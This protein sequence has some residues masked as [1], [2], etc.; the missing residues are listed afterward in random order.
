MSRIVPEFIMGT[1]ATTS[2]SGLPELQSHLQELE[3]DGTIPFNAKL[4]DD[5]ELQLTGSTFP[6]FL[7][8]ISQS[9]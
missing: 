4:F 8:V 1:N 5:V 9:S 2:I 6:S 3:N 7:F